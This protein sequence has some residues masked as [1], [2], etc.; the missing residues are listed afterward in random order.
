[1]SV[2]QAPNGIGTYLRLPNFGCPESLL[3]HVKPNTNVARGS[4]GTT[5]YPLRSAGMSRRLRNRPKRPRRARTSVTLNT[6]KCACIPSRPL[7]DHRHDI[8]L[9]SA[10]VCARY[11][12]QRSRHLLRRVDQPPHPHRPH[13]AH[14]STPTLC[15][16]SGLRSPHNAISPHQISPQCCSA[17]FSA[18]RIRWRP[19]GWHARHSLQA[20]VNAAQCPA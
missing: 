12:S 7:A 8:A 16:G 11:T 13:R 14:T 15:G 20:A 17:W 18:P 5:N 2:P 3:F 19:T 4:L 9:L 10:C 6:G 1:M